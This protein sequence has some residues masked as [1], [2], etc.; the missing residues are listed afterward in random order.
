MKGFP[1]RRVLLIVGLT[2]AL[3]AGLTA[4]IGVGSAATTATTSSTTTTAKVAPRN[5]APPTIS[6][7]AQVGQTLTANDGTWSG[8]TPMTFK[9]QW[10]R[11]DSNGGSCSAISGATAKTYTLKA[12]DSGNTLRVAVTATNSV[13]SSTATSVPTGV[14]TTAPVP[15]PTGCPK[16]AASTQ[17]VDVADISPPARLQVDQF[18]ATPGVI[19]MSVST[20]TMRVHVSDTCGQPVKNAMVYMTAVPYDQVTIPP[21]ATT[22]ANGWVT[23]TFNREAGFPASRNQQLM[24]FFVR[25]RKPSDTNVLAGIST[26]RLISIPVSL[27]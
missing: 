12:V 4:S 16:T 21:E 7:Q 2:A 19:R 22:D 24:V 18:V 11:C 14:V 13:G 15:A 25:A 3:A 27:H 20:F 5:T 10:S 23:L 6:G 9:Y 1:S 17:A 26:R 8:T